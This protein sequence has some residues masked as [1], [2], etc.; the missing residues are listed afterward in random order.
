MIQRLLSCFVDLLPVEWFLSSV[1]AIGYGI[2][3]YKGLLGMM[4]LI[5]KM[6]L[7]DFVFMGII[8]STACWSRI[9]YKI[10]SLPIDFLDSTI[11]ILQSNQLNGPMLLM[12]IAIPILSCF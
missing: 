1:M 9:P 11:S 7:F 6:L 5:L 10:G 12:S 3:Y 4:S 8:V 2:V